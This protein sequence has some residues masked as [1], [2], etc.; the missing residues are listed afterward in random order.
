[1]HDSGKHDIAAVVRATLYNRIEPEHILYFCELELAMINSICDL[2]NDE[3]S[4]VAVRR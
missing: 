1:M 3:S 2:T 4:R